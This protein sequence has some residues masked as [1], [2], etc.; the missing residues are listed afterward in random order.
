MDKL[1][2]EIVRDLLPS[3]ADGL[4]AARTN[5]AVQDHLASCPGCTEALTAITGR[6]PAL[7]QA[8]EAE[9]D[10]L[11]KARKRGRRRLWLALAALLVIVLGA[12]ALR[13]Y[14][15]GTASDPRWVGSE[16]R[17]DGR[18]VEL[19]LMVLD[20]IHGVT[21]PEWSEDSGIVTVRTRTVL[22]SPLHAGDETS[23]FAASDSVRRVV[24]NGRVAWDDGWPI[25]PR[26]A[27]IWETAHPYVGDAS[28]NNATAQALEL[29]AALGPWENE[30]ET[31][32]APYGWILTLQTPVDANYRARREQ[33]M[34]ELA[35][36]MLALIGN[37]DRVTFRYT[38][39][40]APCQRSVTTQQAE[41]RCGVKLKACADSP[42]ALE[43]LL[44]NLGW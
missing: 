7:P 16:V 41:Q 14:V 23:I 6:L 25:S 9:I 4:T 12:A 15:V 1:P 21:T 44:Q 26:T 5:R 34:D 37:L 19:R 43:A 2:C 11:K 42:A 28:A 17:V 20:S 35:Y 36:V 18:V 33:K 40:G 10:Y 3:Y 29:G 31:E 27:A 39:D 38:V 30:L 8:D 13:A 24:V 22:A 32:Q